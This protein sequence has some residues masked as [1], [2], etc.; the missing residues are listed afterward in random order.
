MADDILK[1]NFIPAKTAVILAPGPNGREHWDKILSGTFVIAVNQAI[2]IKE[3][4][5]TIWLASDGTLPEKKW[6]D[7]AANELIASNYDLHDLDK[8]T[9]VFDSGK[10]LRSYPDVKYTFEHGG[11]LS[12]QP[13]GCFPGVLRGG[14]TVAAQAMQLAYHL[15][16]KKIILCGVDMMGKYYFNGGMIDNIQVPDNSAGKKWLALNW[17]Q[18]LVKWFKENGTEVNSISKTAIN[19]A[20]VRS[21]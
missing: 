6:F 8:P 7:K 13:W 2:E 11:S 14:A 12:K 10:L 16:C 4:N 17:M 18:I 9:P 1:S 5:K 20:K 3:V 21:V 19:V 15:G